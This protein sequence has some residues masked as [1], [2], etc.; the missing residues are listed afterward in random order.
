[1]L[2]S[3]DSTGVGQVRRGSGSYGLGRK[4]FGKEKRIGIEQDSGRVKMQDLMTWESCRFVRS[5][6]LGLGSLLGSLHMDGPA[7]YT[8]TEH[9][10][11]QGW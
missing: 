3:T 4:F 7:Q 8:T 11:E 10:A 6:W 5:I 9:P 2:L 1:M